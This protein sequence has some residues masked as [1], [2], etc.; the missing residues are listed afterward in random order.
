MPLQRFFA[1][2][3]AIWYVRVTREGEKKY[4]LKHEIAVLIVKIAGQQLPR[5]IHKKISSQHNNLVH[6]KDCV[7]NTYY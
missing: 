1:L 3:R 2:I 7:Q 6:Y 4:F 5:G